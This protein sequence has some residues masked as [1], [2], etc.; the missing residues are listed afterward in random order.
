MKLLILGATRGVGQ[1]VLAQALEAGHDVT[2]FARSSDTLPAHTRLRL[3]SGDVTDG[4]ALLSETMRGQDV[5]VSALGKGPTLKSERL[6]ERSVPPILAT[7]QAQGVRRLIFTSAMGV[8][9]TLHDVPLFSR[10]MIRFLLKD[11]YA[12]KNVGEAPIHRSDLDWT[13][14][15]P[16]QLTDGP[17]TQRYRAGERLT[18]RGMPKISRADTAHFILGQLNDPTYRR[19]VVTIA[20]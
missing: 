19:K 5:V 18:L 9:E 3:V 13:L 11:I 6:V 10:L 8:G 12:D 1:Q 16:A 15:Q 4:S 14:V 7:M 17:L 2:A 20:Y